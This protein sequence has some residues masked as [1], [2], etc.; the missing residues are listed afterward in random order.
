MI[1]WSFAT[2]WRSSRLDA[3]RCSTPLFERAAV[4]RGRL[5]RLKEINQPGFSYWYECTSRHF[6]LALT[7]LTVADKFKRGDGA[8]TGEL[9][10]HLGNAVGK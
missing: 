6:T 8:K 1:R 4:Y 9:D 2:T 3:L 10:F 7:P 5:K